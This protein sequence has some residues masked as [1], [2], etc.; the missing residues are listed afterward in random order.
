MAVK[1]RS[2]LVDVRLMMTLQGSYSYAVISFFFFFFLNQISL[3]TSSSRL[4]SVLSP[5]AT[6]FHCGFQIIL[7]AAEQRFGKLSAAKTHCV[8]VDCMQ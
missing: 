4:I 6:D 3:S 5:T 8:S 2:S 7:I 1:N